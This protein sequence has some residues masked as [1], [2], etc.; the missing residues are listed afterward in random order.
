MFFL[1]CVLLFFL[2]LKFFYSF[3]QHRKQNRLLWTGFRLR[4]F[5]FIALKKSMDSLITVLCSPKCCWHDTTMVWREA[6]ESVFSHNNLTCSG[7]KK[8]EPLSQLLTLTEISHL[9]LNVL[10][11]SLFCARISQIMIMFR[12]LIICICVYQSPWENILSLRCKFFLY[13]YAKRQ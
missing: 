7:N 9:V 2:L 3:I 1:Y 8:N 10:V 6:T 4:L 5:L 13:T 11:L 12:S